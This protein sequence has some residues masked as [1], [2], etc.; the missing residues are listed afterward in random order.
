MTPLNAIEKIQKSKASENVKNAL[1]LL[2][3]EFDYFL[4]LKRK[5]S[6]EGLLKACYEGFGLK[7][8]GM[9]GINTLDDVVRKAEKNNLLG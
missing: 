7:F 3:S 4:Q 1:C 5:H 8:S 2:A 6:Q 9:Y